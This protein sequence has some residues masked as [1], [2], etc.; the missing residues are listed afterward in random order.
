MRRSS[1]TSASCAT[2]IV[3][4]DPTAAL[5]PVFAAVSLTPPPLSELVQPGRSDEYFNRWRPRLHPRTIRRWE[6]D[7]NRFGYSLLDLR[8]ADGPAL[9]PPKAQPRID[10]WHT[11][12]RCPILAFG[13]GMPIGAANDRPVRPRTTAPAAPPDYRLPM[14]PPRPT[15]ADL[16]AHI[17]HLCDVHG[18]ERIAGRRGLAYRRGPAGRRQPGI[19]IPPVRSQITY[20][21]ALHEIG[22]LLG[23]AARAL[24]SRRRRRRGGGRS[25][26]RSSS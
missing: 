19:R 11:R 13:R 10:G 8:R 4:A 17:Q 7:V 18:I 23:R 1:A 14:P 5:G 15:V 22:H 20:A 21:V 25:P 3:V 9:P 2:S 24:G 26:T 12:A 6:A 16:D